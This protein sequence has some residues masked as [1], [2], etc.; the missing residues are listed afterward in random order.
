MNLLLSS[1]K[2][3]LST[4][5]KAHLI[6]NAVGKD[7][8]GIVS[9]ISKHVTDIGGN[10]GESQATKLGKH[11]SM[12]MIIDIPADQKETLEQQLQTMQGMNTTVF[13]TEAD[14]ASDY[15]PQIA[16]SGYFELEG[17]NYPGIVH[18]VTTFL[19][20]NG[21]SVDRLETS[22][23]IAPHGG[24]LLFKMKGV[25]TAL[26]P[27]AAG[28]DVEQI[29]SN[30]VRLGDDLNCDLSMKDMKSPVG[31]DDGELRYGS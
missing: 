25:A 16:Y 8:L 10:V 20:Q 15:T 30:L 3:L 4:A 13:E 27:L 2:A 24:T 23:E 9:E 5:S 19:A 14:S 26:E 28:F 31:R 7:R 29:K 21:L 18:K 6:V 11:F 22:D 12:M 17:A 1:Q